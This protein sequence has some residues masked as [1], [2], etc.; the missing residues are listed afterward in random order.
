MEKKEKNLV[1]YKS[2]ANKV[3]EMVIESI[4][5]NNSLPWV[6]PWVGGNGG[7]FLE[8]NARNYVTGKCY[9]GF[10]NQLFLGFEGEYMTIKQCNSLGGR[11]KKGSVGHTIFFSKS[12][13]FKKSE[14]DE[15]GNEVLI[16]K[17]VPMY[18]CYTVFSIKDCEKVN[19]DGTTSPFPTKVAPKVVVE[20]MVVVED[21]ADAES[22]INTY[23]ATSGL[24]FI[25]NINSSSAYYS[26]KEDKVV[27]PNKSQFGVMNE[28]YSTTFHEL[29]HST[30]IEKRCNRPQTEDGVKACFG[31]APY[32]KE[33]LVAELGACLCLARLG[34]STETT[35]RNSVA[36]LQNWL[37]AL[38][39]D[40]QMLLWAMNRADKA[41]S[42]IF[43][44]VAET[45]AVAE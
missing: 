38:Q 14:I 34:I 43:G 6:K 28:Y 3:T 16:A 40:T 42:F 21:N 5:K 27:V 1:S 26:P 13:S 23:V 24:T 45:D 36:Y 20:P 12:I 41:T 9:K 32:A 37:G 25:N 29:T 10:L 22:A 35:E 7:S 15:D 2:V 19:E 8:F 30:L 33:E 31:N 4:K 17:T 44:D 11:V 18:K 39:K